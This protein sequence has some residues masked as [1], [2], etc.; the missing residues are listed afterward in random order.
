MK[1]NKRNEYHFTEQSLRRNK[2]ILLLKIIDVIKHLEIVHTRTIVTVT[3]YP[4]IV[5]V[6]ILLRMT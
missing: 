4:T 1:S 3:S 2:L 6:S 5:Y